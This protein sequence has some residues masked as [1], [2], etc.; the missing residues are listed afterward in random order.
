MG[1]HYFRT[2]LSVLILMNFW[3]MNAHESLDTIPKDILGGLKFRN[4]TPAFVSGRVGDFAVNPKN[5]SEYY[6]AVASGHIWK[7]ENNGTTFTPVFDNYGVYSIGCLA[8]DP[9]NSK[10]VWAG[11]GENN[12]QRSVSYG[13]GVYK[14]VDGGKSWTKMGLEN[15]MQIG[16]IQIDP[17]NSNVVYVA[18]EG[19]VWGP[20]GDR[21][22]YKTEN[23]GKTWSK[24]LEISEHTGVNNVVLSP[25]DPD[26][27]YATSEQRRRHPQ[28]RI[29]G[30][31]ESEVFKS[32]DAGKTWKKLTSGIPD[33]HKGGMSIAIS[34]VDPNVVYIMI[35]A[36]FEKGG[37]FRSLDRGES[38]VKMS[39]YYASG[40]YFGEIF[41]DPVDK[42]IIYALD[43]VSRM[44]KD[45]GK[46]WESIG[47]K[48]RHVDDHALWI[49]PQNT[50]HFM[51]G[52]DGGIYE[53]FDGGE[54]FVHKTNLPVTQFYRVSTDNDFPFYNIYGGTQDNS[55]LGAPS[56]TIYAE[57]I[58]RGDWT[59]TLGGDGFWQAVDPNDPDIIYSEYQYGNA[60]RF[61]KKTG[62]RTNIKPR[63]RAGEETYKWNWNTPLILS[64]HNP[65][66]LY[67]AANKIFRS[68]DRGDSWEVL[69]E[70]ITRGIPRDEWPVMD[71]Y[72]SIDAVAKNM[73]T[74]LF[75]M[76]VSLD[77]SPVNGQILVAGT[78]DGV[79]QI[80][81]D[82]GISWKKIE[83]FPG[84]P[85]FT[86]IS[87][88][89]CSK[90]DEKTIYV[91]FDNKKRNDLKPYILK[92][93]DLGDTWVNLTANL[94]A[95]GPVLTLNQDHKI[96]DLLFAGTEFGVFFSNDHGKIWTQL[97]SGMPSIAVFDIAI[98]ERENDLVLATFGRGFYIL[99]DY[100]PLRQ[101]NP[102]V[103]SKQ[104][105]LFEV[106][107]ALH[108]LQARRGGYGFGSMEYFSENRTYGA[109]FTY[110]L[111]NVPKTLRE[112]RKE[113]EKKLFDQKAKIPIPTM[114]ELRTE[115]AELPPVLMFTVKDSKGDVVNSWN[116]NPQKGINR[117]NW[118]MRYPSVAP[119]NAGKNKYDPFQ[120]RSSGLFAFP[121]KYTVEM[122]LQFR[123]SSWFVS[124]P[125]SFDLVPVFGQTPP[126][127]EQQQKT[128]AFR[129]KAERTAATIQSAHLLTDRLQA[130]LN[131]I[132][133]TIHTMEQAKGSLMAQIDS[134][135]KILEDIKWDLSGEV[136]K[137]SPEERLPA[138]VTIDDRIDAIFA[139]FAQSSTGLTKTQEDMMSILEKELPVLLD[140]LERVA[141]KDMMEIGIMLDAIDAPWTPGRI[142]KWRDN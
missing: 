93:S 31:P 39:D 63:E 95:N 36:Q 65:G 120:N 111:S 42:D 45:G 90:Y 94:P 48:Y 46:T 68:E 49:D 127:A 43:V 126:D 37:L 13:N 117:I 119:V 71:R 101:L 141:Q 22:L 17:R 1:K 74:S 19:S 67:M 64:K 35:E 91:S 103:L 132:W 98:Q 80:T 130:E 140:K 62:E 100:S 134:S 121:G 135:L 40:Q 112:E 88:I 9:A 47:L 72:W 8:M 20:G 125:Q 113:R 105:H 5:H 81:S 27:I 87:D 18:A 89:L 102:D 139:V 118:N 104:G 53:T 52:G 34:P 116:V 38:F 78:D 21:G 10:V 23:G 4:L 26:I 106:K 59:I 56:S 51:I 3:V 58:S 79:L 44:S 33:V 114:D 25:D 99:D 77:E 110:Y 12:H 75:G 128:L 136:P 92:S 2:A 60:Y 54:N 84:I 55:S 69:T 85:E 115:E 16:M 83:K 109:V 108:Y 66:R 82:G 57:G 142:P 137:A 86:Y 15:S 73:S 138:K 41:C 61:N 24:I 107:D 50:K 133:Q 123:D 6:V 11:T 7:T 129:Q 122:S 28:I 30:G 32:T 76:A 14:T 131:Q 96:A 29:G 124:A 97:K 70:D